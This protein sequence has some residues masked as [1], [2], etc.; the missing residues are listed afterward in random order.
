MHAAHMP[1]AFGGMG[2]PHMQQRTVE[3]VCRITNIPS[4][5]CAAMAH[6]QRQN[7]RNDKKGDYG[8]SAG[9]SEGP[10]PYAELCQ[11]IDPS[12]VCK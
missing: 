4:A 1:V 11:A 8:N 3:G 6:H 10:V 9:Y 2:V 7:A 12:E 5:G